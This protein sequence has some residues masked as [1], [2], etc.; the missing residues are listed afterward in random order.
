L[1]GS[2]PNLQVGQ[3]TVT[4]SIV[5]SAREVGSRNAYFRE[6]EH[7]WKLE[8]LADGTSV[9]LEEWRRTLRTCGSNNESLADF[10]VCTPR[11]LAEIVCL[12]TVILS[13]AK[14]S[15]N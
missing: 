10:A 13:G 8:A 2:R 7:K 4:K 5:D 11:G 9:G 12:T 14:S 3:G 1:A 6:A 15:T